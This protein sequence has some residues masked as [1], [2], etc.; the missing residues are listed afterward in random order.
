MAL[1]RVMFKFLESTPEGEDDVVSIKTDHSLKVRP[2]DYIKM[3]RYS[4]SPF[5]VYDLLRMS[6]TF[7]TVDHLLEMLHFLNSLFKITRIKNK[8]ATGLS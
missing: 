1:D 4:K 2:S 6:A 7:S 8:M 5:Y 3:K